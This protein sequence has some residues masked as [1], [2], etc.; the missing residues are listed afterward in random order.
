MSRNASNKTSI[1]KSLI[2]YL[3][4]GMIIVSLIMTYIIGRTVL[5]NNK[6]QI[7]KS[8]VT[9]TEAKGAALERSMTE[10]VFSAESLAGTLGGTWAIPEK[11]RQSAA[12]QAIR[13][14]VKSSTIDS[15]WAYWLP[16]MFDHKDRL[17][18]DESDNP[19]G[20]M[21]IHYIRDKN[22]RI[23]NESVSIYRRSDKKCR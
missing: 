8:I 22:G 17:R 23:K 21:K 16:D 6:K 10:I 2:L 11:Q 12:E 15:A 3:G 19:T 13:A 9:L 20:Q 14:M 4:I 7:T 5:K 18:A 1:K